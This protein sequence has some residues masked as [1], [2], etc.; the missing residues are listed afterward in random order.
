MKRE[1]GEVGAVGEKGKTKGA[2][3]NQEKER[4]GGDRGGDGERQRDEGS[5]G[6]RWSSVGIGIEGKVVKTGGDVMSSACVRVPVLII[7]NCRR[8]GRRCGGVSDVGLWNGGRR[9][10]KILVESIPTSGSGMANF[11]ADL[12]R[13]LG[14]MGLWVQGRMVEGTPPASGSAAIVRSTAMG[15]RTTM[16]ATKV[17]GCKIGRT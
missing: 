6:R 14:G 3:G 16:A 10:V 8:W 7:G 1:S 9:S 15:R 5:G 17:G 11:G 12:T 4:T 2:W 13:W